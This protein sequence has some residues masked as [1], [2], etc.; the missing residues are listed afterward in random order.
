[1]TV[2]VTAQTASAEGTSFAKA[3]PYKHYKPD[4]LPSTWNIGSQIGAE[5]TLSPVNFGSWRRAVGS[6]FVA[7]SRK[8][9]A[10]RSPMR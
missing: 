9:S 10:D 7:E 6:E 3:S 8:S 1:V 4:C 2:A 5:M